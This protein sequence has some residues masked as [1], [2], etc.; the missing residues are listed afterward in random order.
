MSKPLDYPKPLQIGT[1]IHSQL[2]FQLNQILGDVFGSFIRGLVL[3]QVAV[4]CLD[5]HVAAVGHQIRNGGIGFFHTQFHVGFHPAHTLGNGA[6]I[7]ALILKTTQLL[8]KLG[9][10]LLVLILAV[11]EFPVQSIAFGVFQLIVNG[12][13]AHFDTGITFPQQLD[14]ILFD[15]ICTS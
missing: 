13:N 3:I 14:G 7:L 10:K 12:R 15:H 11:G 1:D 8:L 6:G 9:L 2:G 5:T 4:Q